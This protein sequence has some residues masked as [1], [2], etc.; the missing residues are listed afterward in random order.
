MIQEEV[1]QKDFLGELKP[2]RYLHETIDKFY[3]EG[4]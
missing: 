1:L 4:L 2:Y 3:E